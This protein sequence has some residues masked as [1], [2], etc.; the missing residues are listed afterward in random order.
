M[1]FAPFVRR[2]RSDAEQSFVASRYPT[3]RGERFGSWKQNRLGRALHGFVACCGVLTL[4]GCAGGWQQAGGPYNDPVLNLEIDIPQGWYQ[5]GAPRGS[6]VLTKNGVSIEA[7]TVSRDLLNQKLP[8][9][10]KR[11][12][13]GMSPVDATDVDLSN[14]QFAPGITGFQEVERGTVTLDGHPCYH[15]TYTYI[16]TSGEPQRVKDYGCIIDPTIY[17]FHFS[18]AS[19]KWFPQSLPTFDAL[20]NSVR[21]RIP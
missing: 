1:R 7:I 19:Q 4:S 3:A 5:I 12:Q 9:T 18:A 15:Y 6:I 20:V 10:S 21:F 2:Y 17:H 14:H 11:F 16:E 13:A 8:N